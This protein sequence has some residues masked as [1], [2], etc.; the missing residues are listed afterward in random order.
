MVHAGNDIYSIDCVQVVV[1]KA[2][3]LLGNKF[4]AAFKLRNREMQKNRLW[5]HYH[6]GEGVSQPINVVIFI[7]VYF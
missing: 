6:N 4:C 2:D 7:K 3:N 1:Q 5:S